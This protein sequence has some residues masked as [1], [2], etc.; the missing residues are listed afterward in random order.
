M[1]TEATTTLRLPINKNDF[2]RY[3]HLAYSRYL[4]YVKRAEL[5]LLDNSGV[6]LDDLLLKGIGIFVVHSD[7]KYIREIKSPEVIIHSRFL[8]YEGG[9]KFGIQSILTSN[10]KKAAEVKNKQ[11]FV[12]FGDS[13]TEV[14][15]IPA[16]FLCKLPGDLR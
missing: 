8:P 9:L 14:I 13:R 7:I 12:R 2:D 15:P 1:Q 4:D 6:N 16:D 5:D 3:N 11:V 10:G